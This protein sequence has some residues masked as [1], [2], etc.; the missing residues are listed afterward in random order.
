[1]ATALE[2]LE[3]RTLLLLALDHA[4]L[5][6]VVVLEVAGAHEHER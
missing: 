2:G 6:V 1:V 4:L 5:I 3:W